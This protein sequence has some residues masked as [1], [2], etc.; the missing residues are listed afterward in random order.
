MKMTLGKD[1]DRTYMNVKYTDS[2]WKKISMQLEKLGL[3]KSIT[4]NGFGVGNTL[5][6]YRDRNEKFKR[7]ILNKLSSTVNS[8]LVNDNINSS[9]FV[10]QPKN[11]NIAVFRVIP[12]N[13][14]LQIPL[15]DLFV[16]A[17]DWSDIIHV[18]SEVYTII[19]S[20]ITEAS[21]EITF[22]E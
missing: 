5:N 21:A 17:A 10:S 20:L 22:V 4:S 3:E 7:F 2:E 8:S 15:P 19:F 11:V 13:L 6:Y 1:G 18:M 12:D 14:E 16:N 9:F